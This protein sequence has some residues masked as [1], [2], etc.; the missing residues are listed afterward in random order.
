MK[1]DPEH[2]EWIPEMALGNPEMDAAHRALMEHLCALMKSPSARF[3]AEFPGLVKQLEEDFY[4]EEKLMES[5][6][7]PSLLPHREQHARV[8][9]GLHHVLPRVLAGDVE[10]GRQSVD[11]LAQ[12]FAFHLMTMDTAL[13]CALELSDKPPE[14]SLA[15]TDAKLSILQ[16]AVTR[17]RAGPAADR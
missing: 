10:A 4:E 8:L 2:F 15:A 12:W 11:L 5:I 3:A 13:A 16:E 7:F 9:S 6:D 17:M 14:A 1:Y